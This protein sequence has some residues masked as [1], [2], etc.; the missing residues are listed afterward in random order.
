[1]DESTGHTIVHYLYTDAYQTLNDYRNVEHTGFNRA[2]LVYVAATTYN[3]HGLQ[4]LARN[5]IRQFCANMNIF[6][7]VKLVRENFSKPLKNA[8]WFH[9]YLGDKIQ[10]E[11]EKDYTV[12]AKRNLFSRIHDASLASILGKHM[13]R[14]YISRISDLLNE[15]RQ[16]T[17][18]R[19]EG[20]SADVQGSNV[21]NNSMEGAHGSL[22]NT[23][24]VDVLVTETAKQ[25]EEEEEDAPLATIATADIENG[26]SLIHKTRETDTPTVWEGFTAAIMEGS[27]KVFNATSV[28]RLYPGNC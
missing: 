7:V 5:E 12:F 4:E 1:V 17:R 27:V 18:D 2:M 13:T 21:E 9:D 19:H 22:E 25:E 8:T 23:E 10:A 11:L 15:E 14:L 28:L 3:L 16:K 20:Y 26:P 24:E 6:D